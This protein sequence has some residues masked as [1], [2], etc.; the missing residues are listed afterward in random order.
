M[1]KLSHIFIFT[2]LLVSAT[3]KFSFGWRRL[4]EEARNATSIRA[5]LMEP[6]FRDGTDPVLLD[7]APC[8]GSKKGQI[9]AMT[10]DNGTSTVI[11]RVDY[12]HDTGLCAVRLSAGIDHAD[13]FQ[14][15]KVINKENVDSDGYFECGRDIGYEGAVVELPEG[16]SCDNCTLQW[17]WQTEDGTMY[18]CADFMIGGVDAIT[19]VEDC[20]NDGV[21]VN[22][23][24][25]CEDG[26]SGSYCQNEDGVSSSS[27]FSIFLIILLLIGLGIVGFLLYNNTLKAKLLKAQAES[28][29]VKE[30]SH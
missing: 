24:C 5:V 13:K 8:G 26:Y 2:L 11:W 14:T 23:T 29:Y 18:Q 10:E 9:K 15:L 4:E 16:L 27:F 12:P 22:G 21:C 17:I 19:C 30:E 28:N 25:D 6:E 7:T 3:A 20:Q 1:D